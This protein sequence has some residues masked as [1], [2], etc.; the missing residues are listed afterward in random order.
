MASFFHAHYFF[1]AIAAVR[2]FGISLIVLGAP[3]FAQ[4]P[5]VEEV[6]GV[7]GMD[8][9]QIAELAEG[10]P[11]VYT[12]SEGS[13]DEI[14]VGL[15]WYFPVP[16]GKV[17][18]YFR[19]EDSI[20]LDVGVTAHGILTEHSGAGSLATVTLSR[21]EAQ[22]L[23]NAEPGD[24]FNLSAQE[25][26]KLKAFKQTLK[27]IPHK[28]IEDVAGE[29]FRAILL[30]RYKAYRH[31]GTNA[32]APYARED[33]LDSK[34][35][36]ELRQAVN[37]SAL[38]SRYLPALHKAWLDYPKALPQ[39]G[40][41]AFPWV[42]KTVEGRSAAI[43]RHRVNMDWNG[44]VLVLTREFYAAHSYNS[45]QWITGCLSYRDGTVIFQQVR[46]FTDQVAGAASDVK[47][48]VGRTLLKDKM[49]KSF[50]R[51]CSI[52]SQCH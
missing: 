21:E 45:S 2:L 3:A 33:G 46:S 15:A 9:G 18:R 41:E 13:D 36:L 38:L 16:L 8:R 34:P 39:G 32:I 29:H 48:I 24:E 17:A 49:L 5:E 22:A 30:Q 1:D 31:G 4:T 40:V 6:L 43:L 7:L 51:L 23:L 20:S 14:A 47:H 12:L 42:E 11:V 19:G 35:S 10:Q 44:G 37:E 28:A 50:K 26:E 27:Q 52:L 25:I